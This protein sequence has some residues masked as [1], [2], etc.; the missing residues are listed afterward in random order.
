MTHPSPW[1]TMV[2]A[3]ESPD[4][5]PDLEAAV[6]RALGEPRRAVQRSGPP[7]LTFFCVALP[8]RRCASCGHLVAA[9]FTTRGARVHGG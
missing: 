3:R 2:R 7:P 8:D 5:G 1:P 9:A 4:L 6:A